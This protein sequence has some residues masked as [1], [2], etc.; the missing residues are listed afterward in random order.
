MRKEIFI[1]KTKECLEPN[2]KKIVALKQMHSLVKKINDAFIKNTST[3]PYLDITTF[4]DEFANWF[5]VRVSPCNVWFSD[6]QHVDGGFVQFDENTI[7]DLAQTEQLQN[8]THFWCDFVD[9]EM[10]KQKQKSN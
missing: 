9:T 6:T 2:V 5:Q 8:L 1:M 3:L 4:V 10:Q 7:V